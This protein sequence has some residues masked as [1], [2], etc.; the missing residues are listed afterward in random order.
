MI[1]A[2]ICRT[3]DVTVLKAVLQPA[4]DS[5]NC[6]KFSSNLHMQLAQLYY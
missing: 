3:D 5:H 4:L 1:P 2:V 6:S